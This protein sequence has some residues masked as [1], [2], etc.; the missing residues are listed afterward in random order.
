MASGAVIKHFGPTHL[1]Q[2]K[3]VLPPIDQ[4]REIVSEV[5]DEIGMVDANKE[6]IRRFAEKIKQTINLVWGEAK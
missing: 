5:T 2:M 4:Q 6:L 1:K 3:M